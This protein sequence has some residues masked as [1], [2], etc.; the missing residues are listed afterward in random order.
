MLARLPNRNSF[1]LPTRNATA[2]AQLRVVSLRSSLPLDHAP[3]FFEIGNFLV[4]RAKTCRETLNNSILRAQGQRWLASLPPAETSNPPPVYANSPPA[5]AFVSSRRPLLPACL[6][7][8]FGLTIPE[9]PPTGN[10]PSGK[11]DRFIVSMKPGESDTQRS[12]ISCSLQRGTQPAAM[13]R[14]HW[15]QS[16]AT[17]R[18][19]HDRLLGSRAV[20]AVVL[21]VRRAGPT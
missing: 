5:T 18:A 6:S 16:R 3:P 12:G 17:R 4:N 1:K 15:N 21:R 11:S 19:F 7:I 2:R 14:A 9:K 20:V 10:P 8:P 13:E